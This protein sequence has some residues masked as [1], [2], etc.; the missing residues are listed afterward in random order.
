M[1][2]QQP[3][4]LKDYTT[5]ADDHWCRVQTQHSQGINA[6]LSKLIFNSSL[7]KVAINTKLYA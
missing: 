1:E 7:S 3:D 2:K 6:V 5:N 4:H